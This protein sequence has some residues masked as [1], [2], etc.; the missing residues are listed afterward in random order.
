MLYSIDSNSYIW[1]IPHR[2]DFDIWRSRISDH[3]YESIAEEIANKMRSDELSAIEWTSDTGW[4]DSSLKPIYE[5]ACRCDESAAKKFFGL[6]I[7]AILLEHEAVW[8]FGSYNR[9][10]IQIEGLTFFRLGKSP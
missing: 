4:I 7:W 9:E 2:E 10:N 6:I 3:E 5:K 1:T 8:G